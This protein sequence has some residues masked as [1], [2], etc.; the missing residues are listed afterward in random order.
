MKFTSS[1]VLLSVLLACPVGCFAA[2]K[3][4]GK[5]KEPKQT[6][7]VK[8]KKATAKSQKTEQVAL[9][10]SYIKKDIH[11]SGM[12]TDGASPVAVLDEEMIRNSGAADLREVLV[13]RGLN[14]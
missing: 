3:A 1:I 9:T 5:S 8:T 14:R 4:A 11:R 6:Q 2:E 13:H 12:V 7:V 10:G